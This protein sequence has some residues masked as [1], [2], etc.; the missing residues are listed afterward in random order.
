MKIDLLWM[1]MTFV[2]NMVVDVVT[3]LG[4]DIFLLS[5]KL[6]SRWY[7]HFCMQYHYPCLSSMHT[8]LQFV[9][10]MHAFSMMNP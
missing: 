8:F 3:T 10:Y 2:I 1:H 7:N 6:E 5:M 9:I 4:K